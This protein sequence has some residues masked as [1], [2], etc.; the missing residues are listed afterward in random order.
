MPKSF[1]KTKKMTASMRT[2]KYGIE[3]NKMEIII[4]ARKGLRVV[5]NLRVSRAE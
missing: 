2:E 4:L 5:F 3:V 1:N